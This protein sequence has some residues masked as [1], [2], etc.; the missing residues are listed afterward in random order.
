MKP[1]V[2]YIGSKYRFMK[3]IAHCFPESIENY[4]EPFVGGG[5]VFLYLSSLREYE[6]M[7]SYINDIDKNI[8][9]CFRAIKSDVETV[10]NYLKKL[11]RHKTKKDFNYIVNIYNNNELH[12]TLKAAIF[13]YIS[14]IA[15]NSRLNHNEND[16]NIK[17]NYS[18]AN[19]KKH[20]YDEHNIRDISK[21][22]KNTSIYNMDFDSFIKKT[23]P[24]RGDFVF[25]DPPYY[26]EQVGSYYKERFLIQDYEK[27]LKVCDKLTRNNVNWMITL[28]AHP[29]MKKLFKNYKIKTFQK[30]S[31]ISNGKGNEHEMVIVNY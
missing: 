20:I 31:N 4:H 6:S 7:K 12:H 10:V 19:T 26:V 23:C 27:L 8:I 16:D 24:Q 14:K 3:T 2:N 28:N 17:P 29:R 22:L 15:F 25:F 30:Y 11:D 13:I 18:K 9:N 1:F 5:S 21:V